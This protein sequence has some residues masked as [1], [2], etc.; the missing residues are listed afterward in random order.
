MVACCAHAIPCRF[1]VRAE[2]EAGRSLWSPLG[3]GRTAAVPPGPCG[4]PALMGSSQTSLSIRWEASAA[5]L[6]ASRK[7]PRTSCTPGCPV[8]V[9]K[10]GLAAACLASTACLCQGCAIWACGLLSNRARKMTAGAP[11]RAMTW[12]SGRRAR[13]QCRAWL[14]SGCWP[15]RW[16]PGQAG[17]TMQQHCDW[18]AACWIIPQPTARSACTPAPDPACTL[19]APSRPAPACDTALCIPGPRHRLH[20]LQPSGRLRVHDPCLRH[21]RGRQGR[22]RRRRHAADGARQPGWVGAVARA[23]WVA[24]AL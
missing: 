17:A 11:S 16:A 22:L 19:P 4:T 21:Q 6:H 2:N 12:R 9:R 7:G 5:G 15:T 13:L 3:E 18:A 20:H 23:G 24:A 1:R 8:C 14:T 10:T